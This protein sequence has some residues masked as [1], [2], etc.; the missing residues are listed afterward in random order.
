ML[1]LVLMEDVQHLQTNVD[2]YTNVRIINS[3][4][5]MVL[6]DH[7][8]VYVL[9]QV[10][11]VLYQDHLDVKQELV[12]LM[13]ITVQLKMDV[14]INIHKD[15]QK[16][17]NVQNH[18]KNANLI[19]L[20]SLYQMVVKQMLQLNVVQITNVSKQDKDVQKLILV[21]QAQFYVRQINNVYNLLSNV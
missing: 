7:L 9:Q 4:V 16:L 5:E 8:R 18:H 14:V 1:F 20:T 12:L 17:D 2:Q 13:L 11:L 21:Q 6:V 19:M 10:T 3:D 15:V